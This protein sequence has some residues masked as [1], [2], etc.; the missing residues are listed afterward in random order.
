MRSLQILSLD[1]TVIDLMGSIK[2]AALGGYSFVT[3]VV[4]QHTNWKEIFLIK[5][6][7]QALDALELYNESLVIPNNMRLIRLREDKGTEF[8]SSEFRQYCHDIGVSLEFASPNTPQQIGSNER[9]GRTI[10][11]IVRCLLVDSGL[12]HFLWGELMQTA[13]YVSNRVPHAALANETP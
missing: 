7:P 4:D 2:P 1:S 3:K 6:K 12:P 10:A 11:G 8:T 9:A 13:V 5:A